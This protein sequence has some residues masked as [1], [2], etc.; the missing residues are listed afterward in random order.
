MRVEVLIGGLIDGRFRQERLTLE[1]PERATVRRLLAEIKRR[2][3]LD[4]MRLHDTGLTIMLSGRL[5]KLPADAKAQLSDGDLLA[6]LAP[7]AGG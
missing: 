6:V 7:L 1:L 4:L 3:D 5:L 2:M